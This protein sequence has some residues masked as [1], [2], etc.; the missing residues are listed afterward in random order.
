MNDWQAIRQVQYL[1]RQAKWE[2]GV[3][4]VFATESV[5]VTHGTEEHAIAHRRLPLALIRVGA[6]LHDPEFSADFPSLVAQDFVVTI[7]TSVPGDRHGDAA[8]VGGWRTG[9]N[10]S[11]GRGVMEIQE[12]VLAALLRSDDDDGLRIALSGTGAAQV[13]RGTAL[14]NIATRDMRFTCR[15]TPIRS[16][17]ALRGFTATGGSG[18]VTGTFT[19]PATRS[20][21]SAVVLRRASGATAPTSATAGTG[22]T[23]GS[24]LPTTFTDSGLA[25]GTYSY[26]AFMRYDEFGDGSSFRYS[27]AI[28]RTSVVV[29]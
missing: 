19:L 2:D 28:E 4:S 15:I 18:Q 14:G 16:Y 13:Q 3:S 27:P 17:R 11:T 22:V 6:A 21:T 12:E 20:D 26:A 9:Q 25:A 1:L 29:S 23:L 5:I 7:V 8:V 24:D 10:S